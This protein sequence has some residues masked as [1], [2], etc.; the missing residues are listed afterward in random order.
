MNFVSGVV[1]APFVWLRSWLVSFPPLAFA[2]DLSVCL[3]DFRLLLSFWYCDCEIL[4]L[5]YARFRRSSS[6]SMRC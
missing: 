1:S 3:I 5:E 2:S 4:P 6:F